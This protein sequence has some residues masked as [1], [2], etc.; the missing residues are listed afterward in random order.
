MLRDRIPCL[1]FKIEAFMGRGKCVG[2]W[3]YVSI[4]GDRDGLTRKSETQNIEDVQSER[5]KWALLHSQGEY[6]N[7]IYIILVYI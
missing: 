5:R 3:N 2:T 7:R 6:S 4:L 1:G